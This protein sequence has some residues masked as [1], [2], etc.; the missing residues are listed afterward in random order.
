MLSGR[1]VSGLG[2][3]VGIHYLGY[4]A[5]LG[6]DFGAGVGVDGII[7]ILSSCYLDIFA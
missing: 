1:V 4:R 7:N 6:V 2:V 3:D 5:G